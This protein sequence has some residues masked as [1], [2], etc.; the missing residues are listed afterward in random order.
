MDVTPTLNIFKNLRG[1]WTIHRELASEPGYGFS[2][3]LNGTAS[4]RPRKPTAASAKLEL[5][6]TERGQLKTHN[7]LTL[8]ASRKYVYRYNADEDK[9][10]SWFVKEESKDNQGQ[11]EVDDLFLDIEVE[12]KDGI[13]FGRGEHLCGRDM[14]WAEFQWR[15]KQESRSGAEEDESDE[16]EEELQTWGLRYKVK[17]ESLMHSSSDQM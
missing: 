7:G 13:V 17:G 16:D 14:Y 6:Y 15:M 2:G 8:S 1:D 4:F 12:Q 10:S 11:E 3:T 5:L 9:I